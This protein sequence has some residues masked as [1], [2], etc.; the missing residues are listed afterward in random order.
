MASYFFATQ[1]LYIESIVA[2]KEN[3]DFWISFVI[4]PDMNRMVEIRLSIQLSYFRCV[5]FYNWAIKRITQWPEIQIQTEPILFVCNS[6]VRISLKVQWWLQI[7]V[8]SLSAISEF[9]KF[10]YL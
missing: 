9:L 7:R 3:S 1:Y 8:S 5:N 10:P 6:K 2:D 4:E